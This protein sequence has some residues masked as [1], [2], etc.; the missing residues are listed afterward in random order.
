LVECVERKSPGEPVAMNQGMDPIPDQIKDYNHLTEKDIEDGWE[1]LFNGY[2][3]LGWR[4]Y[5]LDSIGEGWVVKDGNLVSLGR[6]GDIGGDIITEGEYTSFEL[7]LEWKLSPGGNSGFFYRVVEGDYPALYATGPEYQ[8]IDDLGYPEP[9]ND[10]NTTGANYGMHP[11]LNAK[12]KPVGEWNS[13]RLIVDND[14]VEH[15]LNGVKVVEY[16]LWNDEW[17]NL[18]DHGKWKDYPDYGKASRGHIGLQDHG[19]MIWFRNIK[20]RNL[21]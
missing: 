2:S 14:H 19:S 12:I 20:I 13:S 1:L 5:N 16:T 11:P 9:L 21:K 6:G 18:V 10:L 3:T 4:G 17:K 8:I 15:W 7:M